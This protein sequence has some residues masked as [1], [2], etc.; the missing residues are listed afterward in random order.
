[1]I[2]LWNF[3]AHYI[4]FNYFA[5]KLTKEQRPSRPIAN[6]NLFSSGN[7]QQPT[8]GRK[9]SFQ[10]QTDDDLYRPP[11]PNRPSSGGGNGMPPSALRQ[12]SPTPGSGGTGA[13][14]GGTTNPSSKWAPLEAVEPTPLSNDPFSLGDSDDE[15]HETA[16]GGGKTGPQETGVTAVAKEE[17]K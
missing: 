6:P 8:S 2:L 1:M 13:A 5:N 15:G 3:R 14:A 17:K 7:P 10:E 4:R 9:V 12:P 16:P 11:P